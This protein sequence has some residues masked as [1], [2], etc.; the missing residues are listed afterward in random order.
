M[1]IYWINP[2]DLLKFIQGVDER[3]GKHFFKN[4]ALLVGFDDSIEGLYKSFWR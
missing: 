2:S 1:T 4:S 3:N